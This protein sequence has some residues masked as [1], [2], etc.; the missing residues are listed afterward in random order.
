MGQA[1][2]LQ[3]IKFLVGHDLKSRVNNSKV[4]N[5]TRVARSDDMPPVRPAISL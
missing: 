2:G 5:R 1:K 3:V 4:A